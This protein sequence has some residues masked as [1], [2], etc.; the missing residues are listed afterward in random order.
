MVRLIDNKEECLVLGCTNKKHQGE[1][2]G[3]LCGPCH[4]MLT[5]G[6]FGYGKT[7]FHEMAKQIERL[8]QTQGVWEPKIAESFFTNNSSGQ[9]ILTILY[10]E[11]GNENH[12]AYKTIQLAEKASVLQRRSNL[13]IKACLNFDPDF[14]PDWDN[15]CQQKYG[16]WQ[17]T[18]RMKWRASSTVINNNSAAYVSTAELA[19]KVASYLNNQEIK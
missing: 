13:V 19:D 8:K 11:E 14:V 15:M 4:N 5:T 12:N 6:N 2:V 1:F 7:Y 16:F 3:D 18:A 10:K 9:T 17:S